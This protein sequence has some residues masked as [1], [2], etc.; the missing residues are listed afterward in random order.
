[1]AY[2]N[3]RYYR[4]D[5]AKWFSFDSYRRVGSVLRVQGTLSSYKAGVDP[6]DQTRLTSA[7]DP[8]SC[9]LEVRQGNSFVLV[10]QSRNHTIARSMLAAFKVATGADVLSFVRNAE[11]DAGVGSRALHPATVF[12]LDVITNRLR[13]HLF[14]QRNAVLARF[15]LGASNPPTSAVA[16]RRPTLRAVRFEG[17]NLLDSTTAC[18]LMWTEGRPLVDVT[19]SVAVTVSDTDDSVRARVP[20]RIALEKNAVLVQ[21]G[22][23]SDSTT[24]AE[25]HRAVVAHVEAAM[26]EGVTA[27]QEA[28]FARTIRTQAERPDPEAEARLLVDDSDTPDGSALN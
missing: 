23:V 11:M 18:G 9:E 10:Q 19:I 2:V 6:T 13:G 14:R 1:L 4:T 27:D 22:L 24:A 26:E 3:G 17:E 8:T 20:I 12:L 21:T 7:S 16:A 25:V 5:I 15:R 28:R